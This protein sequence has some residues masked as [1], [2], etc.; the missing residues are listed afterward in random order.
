[1]ATPHCTRD[2]LHI[3]RETVLGYYIG[4]VNELIWQLSPST[5]QVRA[6]MRLEPAPKSYEGT[7][8]SPELNPE[9]HPPQEVY[10]RFLDYVLARLV[11]ARDEP[12]NTN[13]YKNAAEFR[14]DLRVARQSLSANGGERVAKVLFDPLLRQGDTFRFP[15]NT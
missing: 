11:L 4:R 9:R 2:A 3:A 8:S 7:V 15:L 14:G 10:R 1:L 12:N 13:A 5:H 6:S